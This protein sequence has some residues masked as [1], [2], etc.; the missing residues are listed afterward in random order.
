[1]HYIDTVDSPM[2]ELTIASDGQYLTGLWLV[3]QKYFMAD[4]I[5]EIDV[6][7]NAQDCELAIFRET[8]AWLERYFEGK[9]PGPIP[10]VKPRGTEFRQRIW[11]LLVEIPYGQLI[12]YGELAQKVAA[13]KGIAKMS[14][15]AVGGAVGHNPISIIIPCHRVVG[16]NGSLTGYGG[17]IARKIKLLELE[18]V[19]MSKLTIPTKGTAL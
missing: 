15:R 16:S 2:G 17:G 12:S 7:Q 13:E 10:A 8:R 18:G 9:D 6:I 3:E 5:H 11:E 14:S 1:M 19:D 4:V